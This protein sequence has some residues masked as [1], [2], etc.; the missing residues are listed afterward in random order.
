MLWDHGHV[1]DNDSCA[2]GIIGIIAG[3]N[4]GLEDCWWCC[5][6]SLVRTY[7]ERPVCWILEAMV[8]MMNVELKW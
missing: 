6:R 5:L 7:G 8:E 1:L 3:I 2:V 4:Y